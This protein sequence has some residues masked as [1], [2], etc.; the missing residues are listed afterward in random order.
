MLNDS[1]TRE[2]TISHVE[3][4]EGKKGEIALIV[5][6]EMRDISSR[7][8]RERNPLKICLSPSIVQYSVSREFLL[9]WKHM[10]AVGGGMATRPI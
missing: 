2:K 10:Q 7:V 5:Q 8:R 9:T 3:G 4:G 6:S 1:N